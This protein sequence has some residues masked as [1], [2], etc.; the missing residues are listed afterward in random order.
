MHSM[1]VTI[2]EAYDLDKMIAAAFPERTGFESYAEFELVS[3]CD[4]LLKDVTT[5]YT[6]DIEEWRNDDCIFTP[7]MSA[8]LNALCRMG[9]I[10]AGNY[11]LRA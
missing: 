3:G 4:Y 5:Y 10:T 2:I 8:F 9:V 7:D 6:H 11:L 1:Q